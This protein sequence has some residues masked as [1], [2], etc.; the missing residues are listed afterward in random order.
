[1]GLTNPIKVSKVPKLGQIKFF[2]VTFRFFEVASKWI[3]NELEPNRAKRQKKASLPK[4]PQIPFK[5]VP[6]PNLFEQVT[7][8]EATT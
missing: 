6:K 3:E 4:I 2:K 5:K 7:V 1:M 8:V